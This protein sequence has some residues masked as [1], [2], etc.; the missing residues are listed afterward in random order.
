MVFFNTT[1]RCVRP[2]HVGNCST[3]P[4]TS[5]PRTPNRVEP[6]APVPSHSHVA[7]FYCVQGLRRALRYRPRRH[8]ARCHRARRP[9]LLLSL[10]WPPPPF[11]ASAVAP[12]CLALVAPVPS[13]MWLLFYC[14]QGLRRALRYRSPSPASRSLSSRSTAP[15]S[16]IP[17][18]AAPPFRASAVAPRCLALHRVSVGSALWAL[19]RHCPRVLHS[20]PR[21]LHR[22]SRARHRVGPHRCPAVLPQMNGRSKL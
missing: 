6:V 4:R 11:R 7:A 2:E 10:A 17:C 3:R 16:P 19:R 22:A 18:L 9:L 12:R 15:P 8:R 14:V 20:P 21:F 5:K 1:M 13:H